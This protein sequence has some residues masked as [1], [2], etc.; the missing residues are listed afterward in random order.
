[1]IMKRIK[2]LSLPKLEFAHIYSTPTQKSTMPPRP[3]QIEIA[4]ISNGVLN[5]DGNGCT[6][7]LKKGD[8]ICN[9]FN[10]SIVFSSDV[11]HEHHTVGFSVNFEI[12]ESDNVALPALPFC[13]INSAAS[14]TI[15]NI[16]DKIIKNHTI[17]PENELKCS[18]LFLEL[19]NLISNEYKK[20]RDF[21]N[22]NES[23]Y[24][25]KAKKYI[26]EHINKPIMQKD[27]AKHLE[28]TPEY[29]CSIFKKSEGCS[30][31]NY[32]NRIKLEKIKALMEQE[33]ITLQKASELYGFS[34]SSYVSRLYKKH[35]NKSITSAIAESEEQ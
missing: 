9:L 19:I 3:S 25:K 12:C 13:L 22:Y 6:Y 21:S 30:L 11:F 23:K 31:I 14:D 24:V 26:Y 27:V 4:Y 8:V 28:I 35:F 16:I 33:K 17:Y 7:A 1:M 18:G 20:M 32:V 29:L 5:Y 2:I 34:D 10:E 15:L